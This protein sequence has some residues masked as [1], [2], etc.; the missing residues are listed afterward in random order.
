MVRNRTEDSKDLAAPCFEIQSALFALDNRRRAL[1][2]WHATW[3]VLGHQRL[4]TR[5]VRND[6]AKGERN[7][8]I[9]R[10]AWPLCSRP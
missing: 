6:P 10:Y 5:S 7:L 4:T 9:R 2:Y 8:G 3:R 1:R